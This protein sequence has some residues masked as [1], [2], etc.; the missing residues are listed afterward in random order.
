[1][2]SYT[3]HLN[4]PALET[5]QVEISSFDAGLLIAFLQDLE[6]K[7]PTD[8]G[9]AEALDTLRPTRALL[10]GALVQSTL[11]AEQREQRRRRAAFATPRR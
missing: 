7:P 2:A 11:D 5:L 3:E 6:T 9:I 10:L 4:E 8:E 1:M